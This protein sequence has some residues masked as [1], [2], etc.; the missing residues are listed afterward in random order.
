[1]PD[2]WPIQSLV[3]PRRRV[4][5]VSTADTCDEH[6]IT[7]IAEVPGSSLSRYFS[8]KNSLDRDER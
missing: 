8:T 3:H 5:D 2:A 4:D 6:D 7:R 1:M